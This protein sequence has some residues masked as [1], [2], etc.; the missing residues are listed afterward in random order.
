MEPLRLALWQTAHP[1]DSTEALARLDSASREAAARGAHWLVTPEMFLTG[2]LIAPERLIAHAETADGPLLQ[3]VRGIA[4]RHRIGIVTGW[5][6]ANKEARPFNSA[7]AIDGTGALLAVHRKTH[8]FGDGDTL[9][10]T[11]GSAPPA[12]FDWRGWRLGLLICFD[13]E[14]DE[15]LRQL[16]D[17]GAHAV[18]VPTANMVGYDQVQ[19]TR[20]PEAARRFGVAIAYANACGREGE[21]VYNGL[22]TVCSRAG[23]RLGAATRDEDVLQAT[24]TFPTST[25][26]ARTR[27]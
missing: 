26:P 20:L 10:F 4:R 24:V 15:P 8:L 16:A 5:P 11:P 2:Y 14:H 21:T 1:A 18:L 27:A 17:A 25:P 13:V 23:E 22:S 19:R 6:E 3:A 7:A 9:R 12:W